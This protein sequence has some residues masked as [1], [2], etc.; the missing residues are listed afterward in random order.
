MPASVPS[1]QGTGGSES[2]APSATTRC[3]LCPRVTSYRYYHQV[4][5]H[6]HPTPIPPPLPSIITPPP[7]PSPPSVDDIHS[8]LFSCLVRDTAYPPATLLF[9]G[10][11][12]PCISS[13]PLFHE[14]LHCAA[15]KR[16]C[17]CLSRVIVAT[18]ATRALS[19]SLPRLTI[20]KTSR[21]FTHPSAGFVSA[22][23]SLPLLPSSAFIHFLLSPQQ[24]PLETDDA[25]NQPIS[26]IVDASSQPR[27]Q[28]QH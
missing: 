8:S 6:Y 18:T 24:Y 3:G 14:T 7:H 5:I 27:L 23:P 12:L 21:S 20:I 19:L 22:D 26:I 17:A 10:H 28:G 9:P 1:V 16:P 25:W 11:S 2:G 15:A 13:S 4:H